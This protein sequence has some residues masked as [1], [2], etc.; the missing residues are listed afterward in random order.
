MYLKV[1]DVIAIEDVQWNKAELLKASNPLSAFT[2]ASKVMNK[3]LWI[4]LAIVLFSTFGSI[5]YDQS[6]NF[7][8]KDQLGF[9]PSYNGLLKAG[10]GLLGLLIHSTLCIW[11]IKHTKLKIPLLITMTSAS[12][13][14]FV[15]F[16]TTSATMFI[17]VSVAFFAFNSIY[18]VLIQA[19]A[20]KE[21]RRESSGSF[22][23]LYNSAKSLGMILGSLVAGV[24]YGVHPGFAFVLAG[25][26]FLFG[27]GFLGVY[28]KKKD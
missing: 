19:L 14:S 4:L 5:A 6:F 22:M 18:I 3:W 16:L 25:S 20:G 7:Y 10:F 8:L 2:Q 23:G 12:F 28:L 24:V 26:M 27:S 21:N 1:E 11:L 9:S 13:L 15:V 17:A